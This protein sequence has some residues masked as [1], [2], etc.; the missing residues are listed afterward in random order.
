MNNALKH[1][2][3][4]HLDLDI[5]MDEGSFRLGFRDDGHGF[6]E[7]AET[8]G[9]HG[10]QNIRERVMEL[11]GSVEIQSSAEG[12]VITVRVPLSK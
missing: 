3:A 12:T 6:S 10:L 4:S 8:S 1:S 2:G 5:R 9:R 11:G 7:G